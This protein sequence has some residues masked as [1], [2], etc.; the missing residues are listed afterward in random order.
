M[1]PLLSLPSA[2]EISEAHHA[3]SEHPASKAA[4][5]AHTAHSAHSAHA[6]HSAKHPGSSELRLLPFD[7]AVSCFVLHEEGLGDELIEGILVALLVVKVHDLLLGVVAVDFL[8]LVHSLYH[9]KTANWLILDGVSLDPPVD[10]F[11]FV[12]DVIFK[13]SEAGSDKGFVQVIVFED[14]GLILIESSPFF[15]PQVNMICTILI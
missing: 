4:H 6:A 1:E 7:L 5:T 3:A 15:D 11:D 2:S 13:G 8:G 10:A 14:Y 9:L 12:L